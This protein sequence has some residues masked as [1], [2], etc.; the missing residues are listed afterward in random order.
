MDNGSNLYCA[1][2]GVQLELGTADDFCGEACE[3]RWDEAHTWDCGYCEDGQLVGWS[4]SMG[5]HSSECPYCGGSGRKIDFRRR[6]C[7][8]DRCSFEA[9][10][11]QIHC[12]K[13]IAKFGEV[14][15]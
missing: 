6:R 11:G 1:E 15:P 7:A 3:M 4:R 10:N 2:C 9:K 8:E 12:A 5:R 14:Q 13:H